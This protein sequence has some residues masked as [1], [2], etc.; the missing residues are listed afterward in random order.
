MPD[1]LRPVGQRGALAGSGQAVVHVLACANSASNAEP[2]VLDHFAFSATDMLAIEQRITAADQ[3][4]ERRGLADPDTWQL[5][6]RDPD[7]VR[8]ELSFAE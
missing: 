6:M 1:I 4:F 8:V 5:F 7:G 3:P 2:A